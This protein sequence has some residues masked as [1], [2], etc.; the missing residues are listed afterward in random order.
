[1]LC[2]AAQVSAMLK[3][4]LFVSFYGFTNLAVLHCFGRFDDNPWTD[5][6]VQLR[7]FR[8]LV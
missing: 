6:V 4:L 3:R 1:M 2:M 7:Q 5:A 8:E